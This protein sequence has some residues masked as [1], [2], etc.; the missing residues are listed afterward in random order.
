MGRITDGLR[1]HAQLQEA[2]LTRRAAVS[3]RAFVEQAWPV[4]EP[5]TPFVPNWHIDLVCEHLE[6]V[7]AGAIRQLLITMP[8]RSMKS[9]LVSVLWPDRKSVV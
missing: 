7:T 5:I 8:P 9:L 4:L 6:A 2:L 1:R 3:L